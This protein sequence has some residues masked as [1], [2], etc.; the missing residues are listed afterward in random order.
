[1]EQSFG[2]NIG[3]LAWFIR[4]YLTMKEASIPRIDQ[5]YE[6]Y[7]KLLGS[8][9]GF[10]SVEEAVKSLHRYAKYYVCIALLKEEDPA[11]AKKLKEIT[12]LKIDT[13]YPFLL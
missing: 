2:E 13:S 9:N 6:V 1:M 8:K 10:K 3:L 11:I 4:D 12:K 5:V 7:K